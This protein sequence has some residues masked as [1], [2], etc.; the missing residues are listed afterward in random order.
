M[1]IKSIFSETGAVLQEAVQKGILIWNWNRKKKFHDRNCVSKTFVP[2]RPVKN[3]S[4]VGQSERAYLR[5]Q[6]SHPNYLNSKPW[7]WSQY[8]D[9]HIAFDFTLYTNEFFLCITICTCNISNYISI[10]FKL[11]TFLEYFL[12]FYLSL[13]FRRVL[14]SKPWLFFCSRLQRTVGHK[15]NEI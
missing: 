3:K 13:V 8:K 11:F 12:I 5:N 10:F 2:K 14:S 6:L 4:I 15:S 1:V 9:E 7:R